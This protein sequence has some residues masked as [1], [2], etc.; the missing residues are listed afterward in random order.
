[1]YIQ[2]IWPEHVQA[3][4]LKKLFYNQLNEISS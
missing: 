2:A 3:Q 1:M 4:E